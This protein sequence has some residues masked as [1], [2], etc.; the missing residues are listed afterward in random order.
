MKYLLAALK[1]LMPG[2]KQQLKLDQLP[3]ITEVLSLIDYSLAERKP[4]FPNQS[5]EKLMRVRR[6]IDRAI[7][8]VLWKEDGEVLDTEERNHRKFCSWICDRLC[9]AG[10][11]ITTNYDTCIEQHLFARKNN[12]VHK[13]FDF[14]FSWLDTETIRRVVRPR[15]HQ[16][17]LRWFKL[18][19]S[20]NWAR[21]PSCEQIY[22]NPNGKIAHQL[23]RTVTVDQNTCHCGD[24]TR[25]E[26]QLVAPS[27]YRSVRDVNLLE[28]WKNAMQL[29]V[30]TDEWFFIGYSLPSE[31]IAIRSMIVRAFHARA[32]PP[33]ITV[34]QLGDAAKAHYKL[35][36]PDCDYRTGGLGKWLQDF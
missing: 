1:L 31:D 15:P 22:I 4:L 17:W 35:L 3:L 34:I 30:E 12:I 19:G 9:Y 6:L 16:P 27:M 18:H 21:C 33:R 11:V 10:G 28:V 29:L 7:Y 25:L 23:F 2:W 13:F 8:E 5:H 26:L 14:G 36:F 32:R 20:L 24:T